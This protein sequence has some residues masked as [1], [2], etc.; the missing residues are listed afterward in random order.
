MR[1]PIV[2]LLSAI[3]AASCSIPCVADK[4]VKE[5]DGTSEMLDIFGQAATWDKHK[6]TELCEKIFFSGLSDQWVNAYFKGPP[7]AADRIWAKILKELKGSQTCFILVCKLY[8]RVETGAPD[9]VDNNSKYGI[10][11][12]SKCLLSATEKQ[13]GPDHPFNGD[14]LAFMCRHYDSVKDFHTALP[15]RQREVRIAEKAFGKE[16]E[17]TGFALLDVAFDYAYLQRY[18]EAKEITGRVVKFSRVRKYDRLLPAAENLDHQIAVAIQHR[19]QHKHPG[20][21][22]KPIESSN[23]RPIQITPQQSR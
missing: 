4:A 6:D 15:L 5:S 18:E 9:T 14:I 22:V 13:L 10:L 11:P 16:G 8:D 23:V 17:M 12:Y 2:F 20:R 1:S 7:G 21:K 3:I 19:E